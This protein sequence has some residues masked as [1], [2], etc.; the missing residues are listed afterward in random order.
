MR[1]FSILIL[2]TAW[3]AGGLTAFSD[4]PGAGVISGTVKDAETMRP[5]AGA[6]VLVK[7]LNTGAATGA[8]GSFTL[9]GIPG[10]AYTLHVS[11]VGYAARTL[12]V[13]VPVSGPLSISLIQSPVMSDEVVATARGRETKRSDIPGTVETV[14]AADFTE[15]APVSIPEAL[16]R[17][18]GIAVSS[19]MPW[20]Q[21]VVIRGLMKDQVIMLVDG[22]RV[23]TA[24]ETAAEFGT[25]AHG[26]IE[27]VE[28]L[29]G[30]ISVLY[31]SGSTGGVVNVITRKGRFT[32][33]PMVSFS[34]NPSFE[35]AADGLGMYE[36][37]E[38]SSPRIYAG[39]SQSNRD[40]ASYNAAG[41]REI[42]NT[43]FR[44]RQTQ[45][46]F[47][48]KITSGHLLEIRRQDFKA[49]DV[50]IPGAR[51]FPKSGKATYPITTRLLTDAVWTWHTPVAW[52]KESRLNVY[53][54]PIHRDVLLFPNT[55][56]IDSTKRQRT[57]PEW[58][59][60]GAYH[61]VSGARWQNVL[62]IGG[63][64]VVAG[65]EG[66]QKSME[67]YR[68]KQVKVEMFDDNWNLTK[69]LTKQFEDRPLPN[70]MQRP[71]GIFAEDA[72]DI[73]RRLKVTLGGRG[74]IIRT[75]NDLTYKQY[76]PPDTTVLW[77]ARKDTDRSGSF[78][79][80]AVYKATRS[81]DLNLTAARSFR[82]PTIEE[83]YLYADLGGV[84]TVGNPALDPEK[85]TFAESG[86][87]AT[88][89]S[90]RLGGQAYL[91]SLTD[92]VTQKLEK[93]TGRDAWV[94]VNA[95]KS[96]LWGFE[97]KADWAA[98]ANLLVSGDLSLT[99]GTDLEAH[100]N[101][102][103]MPP[104]RGHL[105]IRWS[106]RGLWVEP[107]LTLVYRQDNIAKGEITTPGYGIADVT[108]GKTLAVGEKI[109]NDLV[110]GIKNIGDKLYRDHLA[111]SR[112]Y[113]MYG[114][115]RSFYV[116]LR[117]NYN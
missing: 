88:H 65:I 63:H 18:P 51:S 72:F 86:F 50:G 33:T 98:G 11:R 105:A 40:Y 9:T 47:G 71:V 26:D 91:N 112:G 107:L 44:D 99:R 117:M 61:K 95:G 48:L 111:T 39:V 101:L 57:T 37:A 3:M 19:D 67:S 38:W 7:E 52:W 70:S 66:W 78:V 114:P 41:S 58:L 87:T 60:P 93:F 103:F 75:E 14:D 100:A 27:R 77:T 82:A 46:N 2:L 36:R 25:V 109:S 4:T 17:K 79:A 10:G 69:T 80:G 22:C 59:N 28:V 55:V 31:G 96:L 110:V 15:R 85:G 106:A 97:A 116:S 81:L 29:K 53:Y 113:D 83:R 64:S 94:A 12:S 34:L 49:S 16:S 62:A 21:R 92:M 108:A 20:S 104:P 68:T 56:T 102:P 42:A 6:S 90:L 74:D 24:T 23:V 54:Q 5:V 43:Q 32:D 115:G 35:S 13:T 73:G 76:A 45:V 89:G 8:N 84:L 1:M 30:P